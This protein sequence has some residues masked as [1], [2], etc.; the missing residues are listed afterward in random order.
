[1]VSWDP[2][3]RNKTHET[4]MCM[5]FISC[6]S[7]FIVSQYPK[8]LCVVWNLFVVFLVVVSQIRTEKELE[9]LAKIYLAD[10]IRKECWDDMIIK[11]RGI[12]VQLASCL[13]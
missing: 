2:N 13:P 8:L 6:F 3:R 7:C 5:H 9:N 4:Y 1:M 12:E 10:L 11:G